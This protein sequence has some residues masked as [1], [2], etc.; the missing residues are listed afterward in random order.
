MVRWRWLAT[1]HGSK[2]QRVSVAAALANDPALLLA[3]ELT[4]E[5][6]SAT[7]EQVLDVILEASRHRGSSVLLVTHNE[8]VALRARHRLRLADGIVAEY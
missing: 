8:E 3:D 1:G 7:A 2:L 6:D 5:L 4:G